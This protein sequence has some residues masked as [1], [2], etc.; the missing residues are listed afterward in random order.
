MRVGRSQ[1]SKESKQTEEACMLLRTTRFIYMFNITAAAYLIPHAY[2]P[3]KTRQEMKK[4]ND[5]SPV[6]EV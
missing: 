6:G 5:R 4:G 1:A 2:A 3:A